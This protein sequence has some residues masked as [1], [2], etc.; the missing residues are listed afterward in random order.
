[1][2]NFTD[3]VKRYTSDVAGLL[4][5]V[6]PGPIAAAVSAL[7][8]AWENGKVVMFCGNGGSGASCSHIVNDF[9][10]GVLEEFGEG[11][12]MLKAICLNDS[13]PLVSAWANDE[14][15]QQGFAGQATVWGEKGTVIVLVSGSGNSENVIHA[16]AAA[17]VTGATTIALTGFDGGRIAR[18]ADI[19]IH[20]PT[21]TMQQAEDVHMVI[22]HMMYLGLLD[23]IKEDSE[24]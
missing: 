20:V 10:K 17:S 24:T 11:G 15:W 18:D 2:A 22:L 14:G 3:F 6:D 9:Q 1:M 7:F 12:K 21:E 5:G 16:E 19:S 13:M 4:R 23:R 8:N